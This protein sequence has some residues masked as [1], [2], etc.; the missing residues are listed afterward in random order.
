M[1][2]EQ[3]VA[4]AKE[5]TVTPWERHRF[6][7]MVAGSIVVALALVGVSMALYFSSGA[8]QLDLSRPGY[9][10]VREQTNDKE[11]FDGFSASGTIDKNSLDE[12]QKLYDERAKK[13]TG[14]DSFGGEAMDDGTLGLN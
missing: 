13:A 6:G 9:M 5:R 1:S 14:I 4:E 11:Q 3:L 2:E 12:F 10:S 8:A 7:V